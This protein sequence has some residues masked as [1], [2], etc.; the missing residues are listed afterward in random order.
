MPAALDDITV[1]TFVAE[2]PIPNDLGPILVPGE[3]PYIAYKTFRDSAIFTDR[4]LIVRDSQGITGKKVEL[5]SLP[6]SRIDMWSSENAGHLDLNAEMEL[7]TRAGHVKIKLGR[8]V[9]IR[10]LDNLISQMVLGVG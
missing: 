5:Y 4:R 8:G 7:W 2:C 10:R 3:R 6:Y 1:R 9:D